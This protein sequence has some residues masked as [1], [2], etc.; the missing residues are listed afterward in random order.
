MLGKPDH[1]FEIVRLMKSHGWVQA[2][3][4]VCSHAERGEFLII[5]GAS[6]SG[7]ST[8][9]RVLAGLDL[10]TSVDEPAFQGRD[11]ASVPA[12]RRDLSAVFQHDGVFPRPS[13][14]ENVEYGLKACKV[15]AKG[16]RERALELH[17]RPGMTSIHVTC[18]REEALATSERIPLMDKGRIVQSGTPQEMF[19]RPNSRFTAELMGM[20]NIL[21]A[22]I[23]GIGAGRVFTFIPMIEDP[24]GPRLPGGGNVVV[25]AASVQSLPKTLNHT[26]A[27]ALSVPMLI[28]PIGVVGLVAFLLSFEGIARSIYLWQQAASHSGTVPPVFPLHVPILAAS[29]LLV[30]FA[31]WPLRHG[32]RDR[33]SNSGVET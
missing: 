25:R 3:C 31:F 29:V 2:L 15:P 16:R 18:T 6:G 1:I 23:P 13:V 27:V 9:L 12:N 10:P 5:L 21:E 7:K 30:A 22:R 33:Q 4:C 26:V 14:V 8:L 11:I 20:E 24:V 28:L 19:D 17:D 32:I